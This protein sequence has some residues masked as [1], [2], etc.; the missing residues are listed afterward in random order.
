LYQSQLLFGYLKESIEKYYDTRTFC[1]SYKDIFGEKINVHR[2]QDAYEFF[3]LYFDKIEASVGNSS[4]NFVKQIFGGR[5]LSEIKTENYVSKIEE[6]IFG[7]SLDVKNKKNILE[8]LE[9]YIQGDKLEGENQYYSEFE[10]KHVD[11]VKTY[12]IM[13]LPEILTLHLKRFEYD[14]ERKRNIKINDRLEFPRTLDMFPYTLE[15]I[16]KTVQDPDPTIYNYELVGIVVHIGTADSG[17]YY[18][19]IMDRK[20]KQW[21][22][23]NDT[24][25]IPFDISNL[26]KE[27][28]GGEEEIISK[29]QNGNDTIKN[30]ILRTNN[31]Y[32]LLYQ[33]ASSI[34][35]K[36]EEEELIKE[37][38]QEEEGKLPT[39][40][41][42]IVWKENGNCFRDQFVYSS[43]FDKFILNL[44]ETKS[45][46]VESIQL[47]CKYLIDILSHAVDKDS[48]ELLGK[49]M[50][51]KLL[52]NNKENCE[53]FLTYFNDKSKM[54]QMFLECPFEMIRNAFR[55]ITIHCIKQINELSESIQLFITNSIELI[56]KDGRYNYRNIG[57][58]FQLLCEFCELKF[59]N[60]KFLLSKEIVSVLVS[61]LHGESTIIDKN[62][63]LQSFGLSL[64]FG[65]KALFYALRIISLIVKSCETSAKESSDSKVTNDE[66][67]FLSAK[68]K[69]KFFNR[70]FFGSIIQENVNLEAISE[71]LT[72]WCFENRSVSINFSNVIIN[73]LTD[74]SK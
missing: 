29:D 21:F 15:S 46:N 54:R 6:P 56:I 60:K 7:I 47:C 71:I 45:S 72:H 53:I 18:S 24:K 55:N 11:A 12:S 70:N 48:V 39:E 22:E 27:S 69:D 5:I 62:S 19:F 34:D 1:D 14:Y 2:Q 26:D 35:P 33:K 23:F 74:G 32:M 9:N 10:G 41:K 31:A 63:K 3:N 52:T 44:L 64:Q 59:E 20:T 25:V 8:S 17:H 67:L 42:E 43:E 30:K 51:D 4:S 50:I 57:E 38:G 36:K 61:C 37:S 40:I 65:K 66:T 49:L 16:K 73:Q 13:K 68:D 28:F 58:L